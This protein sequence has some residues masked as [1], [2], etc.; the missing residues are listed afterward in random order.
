MHFVT[1]AGSFQDGFQV[2]NFCLCQIREG[3][4]AFLLEQ[5]LDLRAYA[6]DLGQVVISYCGSLGSFGRL[7]SFSLGRFGGFGSSGNFCRFD[8][9]YLRLVAVRQAVEGEHGVVDAPER[10]WHISVGLPVIEPAAL[11]GQVAEFIFAAGGQFQ[12]CLEFLAFDLHRYAV[13]YIPV[14]EIADEAYISS[15]FHGFRRQAERNFCY[16]LVLQILFLQ[17]VF[18]CCWV[19]RKRVYKQIGTSCI[20]NTMTQIYCK[21]T[22]YQIDFQAGNK[23]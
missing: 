10:R 1:A 15:A 14:V 16:L 9:Q 13:F 21:V 5:G 7:R 18:W 6:F 2:G 22:G 11:V 19:N 8:V 3:Q 23:F 17:H 12:R 20:F 4:D